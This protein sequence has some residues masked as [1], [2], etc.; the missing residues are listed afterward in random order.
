[1]YRV[2]G[3]LSCTSHSVGLP[4]FANVLLQNVPTSQLCP[5]FLTFLKVT[6]VRPVLWELLDLP[7]QD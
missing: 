2:F 7:L 5:Q 1:M 3:T 4:K 6:T